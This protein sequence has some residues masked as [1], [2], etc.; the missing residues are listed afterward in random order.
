MPVAS[1]AGGPI[2][3]FSVAHPSSGGGNYKPVNF[4]DLSTPSIFPIV[5][6]LWQFGDGATSTLQSPSHTYALE[7]VYTVYLA[8]QDAG[9]AWGVCEG[10]LCVPRAPIAH[11][12]YTHRYHTANLV[13]LSNDDREIASWLWTF[14]GG[15][16]ST[17]QSPSHDFGADGTYSVTLLVTDEDGLTGTVTQNVTVTN[18]APTA[19]FSFRQTALA[20]NFTDASTDD[21][22]GL[23]YAWD[24]GDGTTSALQSPTHVY[25][26]DGT[27]TVG[28]T[29]TDLGGLTSSA[30]ASVTVAANK[31]SFTVLELAGDSTDGTQMTSGL[32]RSTPGAAIYVHLI[33]S[34]GGSLV[35]PTVTG[36]GITWTQGDSWTFIDAG[37]NVRRG[38][39][40]Y[41][42][43]PG[44][45]PGVLLFDCGSQA[46]TSFLWAVVEAR[47][48]ALSVGGG[49]SQHVAVPSYLSPSSQWATMDAK[50]PAVSLAI[51]NPASGPGSSSSPSTAALVANAQG[52]GLQVLGYVDTGY[53]TIPIATVKAN[54]D[55]YFSWYDPDGIFFDDVTN[56]TGGTEEAY[57][58]A[59][60]T[61]VK[62]KTSSRAKLVVL[63]PGGK[64]SVDYAAFA[65]VI[66]TAEENGAAAY[67]ART[68]DAWELS[69]APGSLWHAVYNC[70]AANLAAV[71][72]QSRA[73]NAGLLYVTDDVLP[74]PYD[75]LPTYLASECTAVATGGGAVLA[76]AA[77][78]TA[79]IV[80]STSSSAVT[81]KTNTLATLAASNSVHLA[82][83]GLDIASTV[84]PDA[85]FSEI[86]DGNIT[87]GN[88]T[89]EVQIGVNQTDVT[90]TFASAFVGITSIEVRGP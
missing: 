77:A 15:G 56:T 57:Y 23:V 64:T 28:L 33:T 50:F 54:V 29:V 65:D 80:S 55:K 71:V 76:G 41:G 60:Y 30:S 7:G 72:A 74:N 85:D 61:Y 79:Q 63:N 44:A 5:A 12:G 78:A 8:A 20:V 31:V 75:V 47:N 82:F 88:A 26:A 68:A 48:V 81:T 4:T 66:M 35:V 27:Y 21:S 13:D 67:L 59:L 17:L 45:V 37:G 9:G 18:L 52:A 38:T 19:A 87:L 39:T 43:D 34:R 90:P 42:M 53:T 73:L 49:Y 36:L 6:W 32:I 16:T 86:G 83:V 51:I 46:A 14:Q 2:A 22:D 25:L 3:S 11:F 10:V 84:T 24:F 58:S 62:A 70:S 69:A 89:L 40:W 1:Q